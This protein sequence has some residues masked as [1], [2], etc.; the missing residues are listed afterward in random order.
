M[1]DI[2]FLSRKF[3]LSVALAIIATVFIFL[4]IIL[5]HQWQWVMMSTVVSYVAANAIS[6]QTETA[7][8]DIFNVSWKDRLK[9][10]VS[11]EFIVCMVAIILTSILLYI[12]RIGAEVWF[13]ICSSLAV[14]Y[15]IGNSVGKL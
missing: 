10:L 12:G 6:K 13:T 11:R 9:A 15:N 4:G 3:I 2:K 7:Y 14:A 8:K 5:P 1:T